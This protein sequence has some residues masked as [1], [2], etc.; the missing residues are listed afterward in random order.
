RISE[1]QFSTPE[2]A[3]LGKM[4]GTAD[5]M[6]QMADR[7]YLE[8]L[9]YLYYEF[10]EAGM[11]EYKN[12]RELYERTIG[13]HETTYRRFADD[14]GGVNRYEIHHFCHRW[15]IDRELYKDSIDK[16]INYLKMI[17]ENHPDDYLTHLRRFSHAI[18]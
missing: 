7:H 17:L 5:L 12:M 8:K 16:N 9:Q 1:I 2:I 18:R 3:M 14:L 15:K 6:G 10:S 11:D 4:L 13:F